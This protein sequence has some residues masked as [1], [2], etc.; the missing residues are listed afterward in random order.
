MLV[1]L[2]L[3]DSVRRGCRPL[4]AL[5]LAGLAL[6]AGAGHAAQAGPEPGPLLNTIRWTTDSEVDVYGFYVYRAPEQGGEF[7]RLNGAP[8]PALGGADSGA[9]YS[10]EDRDIAPGTRYRYYVGKLENDGS[11]ERLTGVLTSNA[12]YPAAD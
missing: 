11:E 2:R 3:S 4:L 1:S 8:L 12:K 7:A 9:S 5:A 10:Y 6:A